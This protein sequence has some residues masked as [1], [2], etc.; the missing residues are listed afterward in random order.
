MKKI[1]GICPVIA[2]CMILM[3][4]VSIL[5]DEIQQPVVTAEQQAV[6]QSI[7]AQQVAQ[8]QAAFSA[9]LA[10]QRAA[11]GNQTA[12]IKATQDAQAAALKSTQYAQAAT[13]KATQDAQA[14]AL[15]ATQDAQAAALKAVQEA[16]A[17]AAAHA[18]EAAKAAQVTQT[19]LAA[20]DE[21]MKTSSSKMTYIDVSIDNQI[22]TYFVNGAVA[23][24][25]PCV[26]GGPKNSTPK[27]VFAINTLVPGK[28][29]TG[30][31]WHVW[32]NRWMRFS[33]NCGIHDASWRKSFG[34]NIYMHNGSH[35]CVNIPSDK[36][37]QLYSMVGIGTMVIVH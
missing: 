2:A 9:Y 5:A 15:K 6:M 13:L 21:S 22:L 30:P 32:V 11:E 37:N 16:Q 28:Y 34:G 29:L 1:Y 24:T 25:T 12:A 31:T 23:L 19:A 4:P 18:A 10:Q 8:H 35:G 20:Q 26:T 17:I 33:G 14:A 7:A 36:A 3:F 27:G